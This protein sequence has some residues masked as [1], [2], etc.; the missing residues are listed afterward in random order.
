LPKSPIC[1]TGEAIIQKAVH[2][3]MAGRLEFADKPS[4]RAG[5]AGQFEIALQVLHYWRDDAAH[6][7]MTAISEIEAHAS[8]R[9]RS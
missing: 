2:G 1:R 6:G 8:L 9:P 7:T 4:V 5:I 3:I